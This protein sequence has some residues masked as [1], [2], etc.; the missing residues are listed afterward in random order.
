MNSLS[1]L[2]VYFDR[3]Y[4]LLS[5]AQKIDVLS[6]I[7]LYLFSLIDSSELMDSINEHMEWTGTQG[8]EFRKLLQG[9]GSIQKHLKFYIYDRAINRLTKADPA[10]FSVSEEDAL[11]VQRLLRLKHKNIMF[12]RRGLERYCADGHPPRTLSSFEIGLESVLIE[13]ESFTGKFINKKFRFLTQSGQMDKEALMAEMRHFAIYSIYRAY[14]RIHSRLHMLNIGKQGVRNRG[15]NIIKEQ[16]TQS[17]QRLV[18]NADGTFS[19][20]LLSFSHAGF[21]ASQTRDLTTGGS[22]NVCNHLMVGLEG[23]SVAYERPQ[24]VDRR[25]DLRNT[26]KTLEGKLRG[27]SP[28]TFVRLMMGEHHAKFSKWL[29]EPNDE[30]IDRLNPK[31]YAEKVREF[32]DIPVTTARKFVLQLREHLKD[33]R[34]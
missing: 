6:A 21:E 4:L 31:E 24:D 15:L 28:K 29:G 22:L 27:E 26:V 14:P 1:T 10:K 34:N 20:V 19:G 5:K 8:I 23:Q 16:T 25:L 30:A 33:F 11:F 3:D 12:L 13:L 18:K 7:I 2:L 32:L 9:K 17:R